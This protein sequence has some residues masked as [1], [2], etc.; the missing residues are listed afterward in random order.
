MSIAHFW[1]AAAESFDE[2]A[3]HGLRDPRVRNAWAARLRSWLPDPP[4][5]VL[6]LGCGTGSLSLLLARRGYRVAGVDLSSNMAGIARRKLAGLDAHVLVGDAADP[7]VRARRFAAVLARHVLWT[8]PDPAAVL[9]R[10]AGLAPAIV[11]IEGVWNTPASPY[12]SGALPWMGGVSADTLADTLRPLVRDL[13][14]EPLTD[15]N[16]WGRAIDDERYAVIAR[17]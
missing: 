13:R 14:V 5:D 2:E 4:G 12:A 10:W 17:R 6:D 16:L 9:R 3:D 15:P 7:P 11:L 8:L 1:D